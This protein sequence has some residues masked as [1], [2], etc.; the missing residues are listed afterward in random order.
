MI[1][2][3]ARTLPVFAAII[4]FA[5]ALAAYLNFSGVRTAYLDLVRARADMI[6]TDIAAD[7]TAA[8]GFGIRLS[9][10]RTLAELLARQA[11]TDP[12]I[13][14]I[15]V[16]APDGRILFSSAATRVGET[17]PPE[18]ED[19]AF[20]QA[21]PVIGALGQPAGEVLV[22]L[23]DAAMDATVA[24]LRRDVLWGAAPAGA[25]A[26]LTGCLLALALLSRLRAKARR[27]SD[28]EHADMIAQA[29]NEM[30]GL[31]PGARR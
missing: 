17:E 30:A 31:R 24:E 22:R 18:G 19:P 5:M 11:A 23:D 21:Q 6:A 9:E 27:A 12:L 20:R 14:S 13:L 28:A 16:T 2:L 25:G 1:R 10:Q 29:E 3:A 7:A 15:D 8:Q 4:G 26:V